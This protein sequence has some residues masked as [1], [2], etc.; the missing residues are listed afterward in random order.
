MLFHIEEE[1]SLTCKP[2]QYIYTDSEVWNSLK[3]LL[4]REYHGPR[5]SFVAKLTLFRC[6][7]PVEARGWAR[8][9]F[10]DS[11]S[12]LCIS[13][14]L[15]HV[16][17]LHSRPKRI[18]WLSLALISTWQLDSPLRSWR[19][20]SLPADHCYSLLALCPP[21]HPVPLRQ[22]RVRSTTHQARSSLIRCRTTVGGKNPLWG[23]KKGAAEGE[24]STTM[25]GAGG[26]EWRADLCRNAGCCWLGS[27]SWECAGRGHT[28]CT[29]SELVACTSAR[30]SPFPA[31]ARPLNSLLQEG[32]T[33]EAVGEVRAFS[34]S[35]LATF[36]ALSIPPL[37]EKEVRSFPL[38]S[39]SWIGS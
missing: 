37:L 32:L 21:L 36:K 27:R 8:G 29:R 6:R 25:R 33:A 39:P 10:C 19:R 38:G 17:L 1:R 34:T 35:T 24:V 15:L 22:K 23:K 2:C 5:R 9:V 14:N 20:L 28:T 3:T 11:H 13:V 7:Q 16:A 12:V 18:G 30:K 31:S 4:W 26:R